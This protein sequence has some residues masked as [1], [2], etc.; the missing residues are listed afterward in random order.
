MEITID[1]PDDLFHR[2]EAVAAR[3]GIT[4]SELMIEGLEKVLAA[5]EPAT[6]T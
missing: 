6:G 1:L 2:A 5:P 3:R 4:L